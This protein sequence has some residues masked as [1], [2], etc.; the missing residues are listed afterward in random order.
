MLGFVYWLSNRPALAPIFKYLPPVIWAYF[1]PML[2]T[3]FGITPAAHPAYSW[4]KQYLLLV[5]LLL[6]T[7]GVDVRAILRLG[8][9]ALLMMLAG[10]LGIVLGGPVAMLMFKGMLPPETWKG[11]AALAGSWIGGSANMLAMQAAVG[12]PD[13]MMG[14]IIVVD[15]VVGYGWMGILLFLSAFQDKFD[16]WVKAD[17]NV[18]KAVA[19]DLTDTDANRR[20]TEVSDYAYLIGGGFGLAV[21]A[22]VAG[23]ALPVVGDPTVI[24]HG[25]WAVLLI[26]TLGLAFSFTPLRK[27]E[28]AG[29]STLGTAALYLLITAIGAQADLKTVLQTPIYLAA[30]AVWILI[31]ISILFLAARLLRAPLFFVA[32]GSMANIGGAASAPVVATTYSKALAPVGVLM[33]VA[34]YVLGIYAAISLAGPLLAWA[35]G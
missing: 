25:T 4:M 8:K 14:P 30:G 32:T 12:T 5:A 21:L 34:G 16:R 28:D 7:V 29:A 9:L 31:H 17:P 27:L 26:V 3:T 20:P 18:L 35:G 11:F 10:T 22:V 19:S 33:A 1:L 23:N 15:T 6:L 13:A 24:S 2:S